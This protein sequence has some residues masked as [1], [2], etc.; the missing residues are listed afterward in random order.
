MA[1]RSDGSAPVAPPPLSA[2]TSTPTVDSTHG[3]GNFGT[4]RVDASGLPAFRYELDQTADPRARQA[5]IEL[6]WLWIRHQPDS[7]LTHW[8]YARSV[9]ESKRFK[10]IAIVALAR[11]LI[12]ALWRYLTTGLVPE[13][14]VLKPVKA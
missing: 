8:F 3:S 13:G 9:N 7:A 14:A 2:E 10:R 1:G 4:W 5:V 12:V 6:A 11:K